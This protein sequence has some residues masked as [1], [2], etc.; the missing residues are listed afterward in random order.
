MGLLAAHRQ[1][2][3]LTPYPER[4]KLRRN[5]YAT[6]TLTLVN[7]A[8]PVIISTAPV[9]YSLTTLCSLTGVGGAAPGSKSQQSL[10]PGQDGNLY[11]TTYGGHR[12]SVQS[13]KC[14]PAGFSLHFVHFTGSSGAVPGKW[15]ECPLTQVQTGISTEQHGAVTD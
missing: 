11:G 1:L 12:I 7:A 15:P 3:G 9:S 13:S 5:R 4:V 2:S 8:A 6:L 10:I 14:Q